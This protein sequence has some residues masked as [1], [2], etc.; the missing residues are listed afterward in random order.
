VRYET[1][2]AALDEL[3]LP[4][5]L[6]Q[7]RISYGRTLRD[8]G[9]LAAAREQFEAAREV[10]ERMGATGLLANVEQELALIRTG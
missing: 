8:G 3:G 9:D 7:A 6:S 10:C 4:I 2:I 1:A 5:E